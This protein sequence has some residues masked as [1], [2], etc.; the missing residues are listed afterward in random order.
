MPIKC[1]DI[2]DEGKLPINE[3]SL[4]QMTNNP[5]ILIIGKRGTGKSYLI[6]DILRSKV[7][8]NRPVTV[9]SPTDKCNP[10]YSN[11]S[12]DNINIKKIHYQYKSEII[13]NFLSNENEN[14][15]SVN[16]KKDLSSLQ[17]MIESSILNNNLDIDDIDKM[18]DVFD[19]I[20]DQK[21]NKTI[22]YELK[23]INEQI[24]SITASSASLDD[25]TKI[26]DKM[27]ELILLKKKYCLDS[28]K[29]N[30]SSYSIEDTDDDDNDDFIDINDMDDINDANNTKTN[31]ITAIF[32]EEDNNDQQEQEQ[33]Q[34]QE[35]NQKNDIM[36]FDDC[37]SKK[38]SWVR[39][40]PILELLF[41]GRHYNKSYILTMS[42]PLGITPEIRLNF[43]YIFLFAEDSISNLKRIYDH[44]GG[45][46]P[47]F[48]SFRKVHE[49]LTEDF[50][51]MVISNKHA[52]SSFLEKVFWFRAS[53]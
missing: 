10:F 41:N 49:Q 13:Y 45:M 52:N 18:K 21:V 50:G 31:I 16:M 32:N 33:E 6:K 5:H 30:I 26:S 43:D 7:M 40:Q 51:C 23:Q 19:G 14:E 4:E 38:R 34:E 8:K 53:S 25:L 3:F 28:N 17:K 46:F 36:I 2:S 42:Y 35:Q 48:N 9:I 1:V 20:V 12:D 37:L 15:I 29:M 44:Y 22:K 11:I 24:D 47:D 39:D 27:K